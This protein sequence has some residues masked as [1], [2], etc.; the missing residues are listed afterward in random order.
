MVLRRG[1]FNTISSLAILCVFMENA[2]IFV[3]G[4]LS[5]ECKDCIGKVNEHLIAECI[6]TLIAFVQL[7]KCK[8]HSVSS[9]NTN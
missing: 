4:L 1:D 3:M 7:L 9:V 2:L 6:L 5:H 8:K